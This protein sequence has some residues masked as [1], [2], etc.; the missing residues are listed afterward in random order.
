MQGGTIGRHRVDTMSSSSTLLSRSVAFQV[1]AK[2]PDLTV[3]VRLED[4]GGRW[5]AVASTG[6]QERVGL[7]PCPRDALA[8]SLAWLGPAAVTALL[9]DLRL[10]EVSHRLVQLGA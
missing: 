5:L 4:R 2:A 6:G 9:V 3:D 10:L 7:G 1:A 8:S